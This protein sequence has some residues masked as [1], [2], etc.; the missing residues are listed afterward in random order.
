MHSWVD[1]WRYGWIEQWI[2]RWMDAVDIGGSLGFKT[3]QSIKHSDMLFM[4]L[5][6]STTEYYPAV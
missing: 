1:G 4:F 6:C 3:Q 5:G 2:D